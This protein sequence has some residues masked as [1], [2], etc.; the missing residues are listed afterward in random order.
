MEAD[1]NLSSNLLRLFARFALF[2]EPIS[3]RFISFWLGRRL[4]NWKN[5]GIIHDYKINTKRT[6]K[7]HYKIE[8]D[9]ELSTQQAAWVLGDTLIRTLQ[10]IREVI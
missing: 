1:A 4:E 9:L 8:V 7:F 6:G 10:K 5:S 3:P 2:F